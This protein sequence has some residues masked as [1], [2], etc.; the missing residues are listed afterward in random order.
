MKKTIIYF[1]VGVFLLSCK[2]NIQE[3]Q[4]NITLSSINVMAYYV[5]ERNFQPENL[6]LNKLTHIIFSF[7]KVID[8]EMRFR[9]SESGEK[10]KALVAM[11]KKFPKLKVM[12]ACGGWGAD[13]FSD[14]AETPES[15]KKFVNSVVAFNKEYQLDGLDMDWEYPGIPAADTKARP[16]DKENFTALMKAL[17]EG[18]DA[19]EREQTL[20]FASAGWERYY[21]H[22]EL[23][24]VM[25]YADFMNVMTYDQAGGGSKF[26]THHTALG[27]KQWSDIKTTDA[28]EFIEIQTSQIEKSGKEYR[29]QSTEGIID[30]CLKKGV[31]PE[32]LVVGA[33]FY[34]RAWKGVA[35][36]N[37]GLYQA[38]N[39]PHTGGIGYKDLRP[40]YEQNPSYTRYWDNKAKAPYLFSAKDSIFITY[41]DTVS[42]R[43]K[44][45]F[46][47]ERSL[48]GI[49]F[50]QLGHDT[51]E[52]DG[53][54]NAIFNA[55]K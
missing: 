10:L 4:S 37:N 24:K 42:V 14:A 1:F 13:G 31:K 41:D 30:F 19:L 34:G 46:V 20:T 16:E 9:N 23:D 47:K 40:N 35:D 18:L 43:L 48:G 39:G 52:K 44:T 11:R 6:P 28:K 25:K 26:T 7:T 15:R 53:L 45:Q 8:G 22:V 51:K 3:I 27:Q 32:Q 50:W 38:N 5:P 2:S 55:A 29:P 36:I 17:R 21:D 54:L 49:M 33:A 12:V